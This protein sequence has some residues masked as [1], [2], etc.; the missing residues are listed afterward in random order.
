MS[1]CNSAILG[2]NARGLLKSAAAAQQ[3]DFQNDRLGLM[4]CPAH[5]P[6]PLF[7]CHPMRAFQQLFLKAVPPQLMLLILPAELDLLMKI[8]EI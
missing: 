1:F 4:T 2:E 8:S 7:P 3:P 5:Q 6:D